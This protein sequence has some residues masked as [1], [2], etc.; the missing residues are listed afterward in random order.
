M[1]CANP[2]VAEEASGDFEAIGQ[3]L[4]FHYF[5]RHLLRQHRRQQ[6]QFQQGHQIDSMNRHRHRLPLRL[7]YL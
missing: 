4:L 3:Q 5:Q 6:L 7:L 1:F 2:K